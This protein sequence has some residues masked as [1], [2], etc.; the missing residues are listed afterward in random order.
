MPTAPQ[1]RTR[2]D[3]A[4]HPMSC[5]SHPREVGASLGRGCDSPAHRRVRIVLSVARLGSAL[6]VSIAR[7]ICALSGAPEED[8]AANDGA[9]AIDS[10]GVTNSNDVTKS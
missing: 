7:A 2:A 6:T 5:I 4:N 10:N 1:T 8:S 3:C 9:G